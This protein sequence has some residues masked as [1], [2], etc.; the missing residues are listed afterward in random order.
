MHFPLPSCS[1]SA[2]HSTFSHHSVQA[3]TRFNRA[4]GLFFLPVTTSDRGNTHVSFA[5]I[6]HQLNSPHSCFLHFQ[7]KVRHQATLPPSVLQL[8]E[9]HIKI[10]EELFSPGC[11]EGKGDSESSQQSSLQRHPVSNPLFPFPVL[12]LELPYEKGLETSLEILHIFLN[13]LTILSAIW[14]LSSWD[15]SLN[16]HLQILLQ[17]FLVLEE[18]RTHE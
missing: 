12:P 10:S 9:P 4:P 8:Q 18:K 13:D 7:S 6:L 3:W 11:D 16:F 17:V 14:H 2:F 1:T 15:V 5:P